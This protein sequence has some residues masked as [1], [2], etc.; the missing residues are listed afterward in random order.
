MSA[1][2]GR[3]DSPRHLEGQESA[4]NT[5]ATSKFP[6]HR[7]RLSLTGHLVKGTLPIPRD[8]F[9]HKTG[10]ARAN[11][12]E[13][14]QEQLLRQLAGDRSSLGVARNGKLKMA[15]ARRQNLERRSKR[16]TSTQEVRMKDGAETQ[17]LRREAEQEELR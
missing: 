5:H 3:T 7:N 15:D 11:D 4:P 6:N 13:I 1:V 14:S 17:R 10:K 8:V 12:A 16:T 9:A 2:P